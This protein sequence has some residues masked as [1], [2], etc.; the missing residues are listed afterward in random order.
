VKGEEFM[1]IA[2]KLR[3]ETDRLIIRPFLASDAKDVSYYSQ[4]PNMAYWMSDMIFKGEERALSWINW[5]NENLSIKDPNIVLAIEHKIDKKCIG[6]VGVHPKEEIDNE[7]EILYGISDDYQG[8]GYATESSKKL[9]EWVF[10]NTEL[11]ILTAIVKPEN[12]SSK[13]VIGKLGFEYVDA[14]LVSYD[15]AM[16]NFN[17][18]K[19]YKKHQ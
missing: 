7:V 15:G 4:Q 5:V 14:R 11:K 17:Y 8:N 16:C 18:Y 6:V 2:K 12:S 19:L 13:A 10:K 3:I 1:D 9:I